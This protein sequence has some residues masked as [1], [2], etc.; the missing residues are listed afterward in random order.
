VKT[1]R[2]DEASTNAR[3][4]SIDANSLSIEKTFAFV[5]DAQGAD[6]AP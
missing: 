4:F 2:R 5:G 6:T 1:Y 3:V